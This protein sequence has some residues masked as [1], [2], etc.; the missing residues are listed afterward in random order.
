MLDKEK[1]VSLI[2]GIV[3]M[4]INMQNNKIESLSYSKHKN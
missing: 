2:N 3:E 4:E 1:K